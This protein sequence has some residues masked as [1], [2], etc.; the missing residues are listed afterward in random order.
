MNWHQTKNQVG[1]SLILNSYFDID[2]FDYVIDYIFF[3][4]NFVNFFGMMM[5]RIS[6][7]LFGSYYPWSYPWSYLYLELFGSVFP[8]L[9]LL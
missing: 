7:E 5:W 3:V 4:R 9:L 8:E 1:W 6:L 2:Y